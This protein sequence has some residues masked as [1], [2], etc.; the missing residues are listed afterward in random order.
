VCTQF[1]LVVDMDTI[2]QKPDIWCCPQK[3]Y[4]P[5]FWF[6][7]LL[8]Y[9]GKRGKK[10]LMDSGWLRV[11]RN[12]SVVKTHSLVAYPTIWNHVPGSGEL[13]IHHHHM[14]SKTGTA[15]THNK[16]GMVAYQD[17]VHPG[18]VGI[19]IISLC[20]TNI[21]SNIH[22]LLVWVNNVPLKEVPRNT[23]NRGTRL[24]WRRHRVELRQA[25]A[26]Q[27]H[28]SAHA[29]RSN[30]SCGPTQS[31]G[32]HFKPAKFLSLTRKIF[33][34]FFGFHSTQ[35]ATTHLAT[36]IRQRYI[37]VVCSNKKARKCGAWPNRTAL[38]QWTSDIWMLVWKNIMFCFVL[39]LLFWSRHSHTQIYKQTM[40]RKERTW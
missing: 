17:G 36:R 26:V 20:V 5:P 35:H 40:N 21:T 34:D 6:L 7:P 4:H 10:S 3:I 29:S 37:Q 24:L 31:A 22:L 38:L 16:S 1:F 19:V 2:H 32:C 14:L 15:C 11:A 39:W 30:G 9:P 8:L 12:I 13:L 23:S 18:S 28:G 33:F 27:R 25:Q